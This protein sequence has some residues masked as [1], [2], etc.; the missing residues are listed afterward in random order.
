M[1]TNEDLQ[2]PY[3]YKSCLLAA[4]GKHIPKE[5]YQTRFSTCASF[6]WNEDREKG[7]KSLSIAPFRR[8]LAS[9]SLRLFWCSRD[10]R[11]LLI[12]QPF[13]LLRY[14]AAH[15]FGL[16]RNQKPGKIKKSR[17]T[18]S[19]VPWREFLVRKEDLSENALP[20]RIFL[21]TIIWKISTWI[22]SPP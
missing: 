9:A 11:S 16:L 1:L 15:W 7:R 10:S 18:E 14:A 6:L 17:N 8:N 12:R 4:A 19:T 3:L 2:H 5:A 20:A 13:L 22:R 21:P